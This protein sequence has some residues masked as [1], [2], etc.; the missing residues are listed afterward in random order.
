[1][2]L[3]DTDT[4]IYLI[5]GNPRV[6]ENVNAHRVASKFFSVIS[7]GELVH[8]CRKSQRVDHN[9]YKIQLLVEYYKIFDVTVPVMDCFGE[10]KA[11]LQRAGTP[12]EDMDLIIA[13]TA[14]T[15]NYTLVT[16]NT[17]HF[18]K[19]PGLKLVNWS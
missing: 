5:N 4:L 6:R 11:N 2:Y 19:I 1:M 10:V 16:N 7:Y 12:V 15:M 18:Q 8:G 3:L 13:C 17:K 9:L 14:L